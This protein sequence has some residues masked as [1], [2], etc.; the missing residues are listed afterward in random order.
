MKF[1]VVV[2][3]LNGKTLVTGSWDGTVGVW[4]INN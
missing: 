2:F 4:N 3:S 1:E